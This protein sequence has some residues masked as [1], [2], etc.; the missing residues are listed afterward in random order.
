[1]LNPIRECSKNDS[2]DNIFSCLFYSLLRKII[3]PLV[4]F[5]WIRRV[6]GLGNIPKEGPVI[7]AFNHSSYFDFICFIAVS[8]RNVHYL[9]AEKF[10]DSF[11]WRP[12]VKLTG[13]IRV[14]RK[15]KDKRV[16]HNKVFE[17]LK[18]GKMIGI[19]PE[20][21]RSPD[22]F[23][24]PAFRGVA[25]YATKAHVP[26]VPIGIKGTYEV[27][28]RFEHFPRFKRIVE[29]NVGEPISFEKYLNIKLN[30]K[31]HQILTEGVMTKIAELCDCDYPY[32]TAATQDGDRERQLVIFDVDNTLIRGQSQRLFAKY[33]LSRRTIG[34]IKYVHILGWFALYRIGLI[35]KPDEAM[36]KFYQILRGRDVEDI[37]RLVDD[38]FKSVLE[39]EFFDGSLKILNDHKRHG[40]RILLISNMPDIIMEKVARYVGVSDFICTKLERTGKI[41]TGNILGGIFYGNKRTLGVRDFIS[42]NNLNLGKT[43]VYSDHISDLPLLTIA[44]RP[45]VVNPSR[46]LTEI[47][48]KNGWP[49]LQFI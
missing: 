32:H 30:K 21:T 18:E 43:W 4:R 7:V 22:G 47:A 39:R 20:G 12:A 24:L 37:N 19:F 23:M 36:K 44:K 9:A 41:F 42:K 48:Q 15:S 17:H 8:P 14:H 49:I 25:M 1:M 3:G 10:F 2:G 33:L 34:L 6:T 13:Q 38:F 35:T 27:L 5:I 46:K 16:V 45:T 31:A 26:I 29:I 28:S 40:R 11:I